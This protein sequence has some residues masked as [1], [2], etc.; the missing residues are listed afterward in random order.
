M[1]VATLFPIFS[2]SHLC[3]LGNKVEHILLCDEHYIPR[4]PD[5]YKGRV[6]ALSLAF[7]QINRFL[8][9]LRVQKAM[10][11]FF[12]N[13]GFELE[14][15][16]PDVI[17]VTDF[18]HWYFWQCAAYVRSHKEV[19][20]IL[21]SETKQWPRSLLSRLLMH[22][23]VTMLRNTKTVAGVFTFSEA[24]RNFFSENVPAI[25]SMVMPNPVDT[26]VFRSVQHK[27]WLPGGTL[28]VLMNARFVPYKRHT[29]LLD[30]T[31]ILVEQGKKVELTF[32]GRED[33]GMHSFRETIRK[34]DLE[35]IVHI[36]PPQP[37]HEMPELYSR[38]DVLVL[39]S[40]NEA[41]G[42]VVPESMACGI[43]TVTSDTVAAN[44]YV[45]DGETGIV[46]KTGDAYSLASAL[47]GLFDQKVLEEMG[48][49]ARLRVSDF[50]VPIIVEKFIK[51][52]D[53]FS[54][55]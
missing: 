23:F 22:V 24:G 25:P 29:D 40:Y 11:M 30:A 26:N 17:V 4:L 36:M 31:K 32:I 21:Y 12:W 38:H 48:Q 51:A 42:L 9:K 43:P 16:R 3:E 15:N 7:S 2:D 54:L 27:D 44:I 10:P 53:A 34:Y 46:F 39:P 55:R 37:L 6:V 41:I 50:S 28:R 13:L 14:K 19:K 45:K 35:K 52:I 18:F 33:G 47:S 49:K 8:Q 20:L 5:G 1:K